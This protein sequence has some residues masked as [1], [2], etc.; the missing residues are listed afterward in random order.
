MDDIPSLDDPVADHGVED[1]LDVLR[2]RGVEVFRLS[3]V[4]YSSPGER[5][6]PR[7]EQARLGDGPLRSGYGLRGSADRCPNAGVVAVEATPA[8]ADGDFGARQLD[9]RFIDAGDPRDH[10]AFGARAGDG[11][12][13]LRFFDL[14]AFA[15]G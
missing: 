3:R 11:L 15:D 8:I 10:H 6:V 14:A 1:D 13:Q 5:A 2:K 7:I 12:A 9:L 4:H